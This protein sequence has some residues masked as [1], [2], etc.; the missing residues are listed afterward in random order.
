MNSNFIHEGCIVLRGGSQTQIRKPSFLDYTD[1]AYAV[2]VH[3][4]PMQP[5]YYAGD[6]L[7][8]DPTA[9]P[10]VGDDVAVM[11]QLEGQL[12]AVFRECVKL[13]EASITVLELSSGK[14]ATFQ[15]SDIYGVHVVVG[16]ARGRL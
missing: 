11:I 5:R 15:S 8:V 7:F 10:R 13:T 14:E 3:G 12:I 9:A 16:S 2:L 1:D 4:D 6:T